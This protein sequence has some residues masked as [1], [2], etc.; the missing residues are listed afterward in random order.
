VRSDQRLSCRP[1]RDAIWE[2]VRT[3][4]LTR[5]KLCPT[6]RCMVDGSLRPTRQTHHNGTDAMYLPTR[7]VMIGIVVGALSASVIAVTGP[8]VTMPA[9][10]DEVLT[11]VAPGF[12]PDNLGKF[13]E[14]KYRV[15][16][17]DWVATEPLSSVRVKK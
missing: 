9:L 4:S 14:R 8:G 1:G 15:E 13:K 3:L 16:H 7:H 6:L 17:E 2:C 5:S 12:D 10:A 11:S